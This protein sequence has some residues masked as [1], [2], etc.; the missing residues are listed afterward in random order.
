M[1]G[2]WEGAWGIGVEEDTDPVVLG[3]NVAG[4][5]LRQ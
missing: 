5:V 1:G 3:R 4:D 2:G